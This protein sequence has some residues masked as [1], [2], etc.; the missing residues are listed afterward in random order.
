MAAAG[1]RPA[2]QVFA[3][4]SGFTESRSRRYSFTINAAALQGLRA[5]LGR[6]RGHLVDKLGDWQ[7]GSSTPS[8]QIGAFSKGGTHCSQTSSRL[9]TKPDSTS[10]I[11]R[12]SALGADSS[13]A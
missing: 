8:R 5:T 13:A 12:L 11:R 9:P 2:G 3:L 7:V 6:R 1:G 4:T 10:E